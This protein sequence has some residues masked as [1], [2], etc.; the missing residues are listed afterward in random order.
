MEHTIDGYHT[1]SDGRRLYW[2]VDDFTDPWKRAPTVLLIHGFAETSEAWRAWVPHLARD[3]RVLRIDRRGFG[4]SDPMPADF[5]WSLDIMVD[6]TVSFIEAQ[7]PEGAHV[8]GCKIATPLSIRLAVRRPDLVKSLVLCGGPATAPNGEAWARQIEERGAK[9]WAAS[10]MDARMGPEMPAAA[11]AW[12]TEFMGA[13]HKSTML[14][15]LRNLAKIDVSAEVGGICCPT[16]VVATD[17]AYRPLSQVIPWQSRIPN[18]RLATIPG[19]GFHPAAVAPD[20]CAATALAFLRD[21]DHTAPSAT[22]SATEA[23]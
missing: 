21:I 13:T 6:D 17:S 7:A 8:I 19:G 3:Y 15:F 14:G 4:K 23:A 12:W 5:P 16:L 10:T 9:D 1:L 11:K 22:Q 20:L 18:S 2:R